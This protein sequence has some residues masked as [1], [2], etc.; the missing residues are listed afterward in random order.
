[1]SQFKLLYMMIN[2]KRRGEGQ[3]SIRL[4]IGSRMPFNIV[5]PKVAI[6]IFIFRANWTALL[7]KRVQSNPKLVYL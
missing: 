2:K 1:M 7:S 3:H 5:F 6:F 4:L